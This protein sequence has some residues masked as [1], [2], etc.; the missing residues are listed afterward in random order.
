MNEYFMGIDWADRMCSD[1][2]DD[3]WEVFKQLVNDAAIQFVPTSTPKASKSPPWWTKSISVAIK[4]KHSALSR[5]RRS[6]S[7]ADYANYKTKRNIVKC[8]LRT[9]QK[10]YEQSLLNKFKSNPKAFYSYV[11]S[12]QKVKPSIGPLEKT[13]GSSTTSDEEIT[14]VLNRYFESTFTQEDLS[15]IPSPPFRSE[16]SIC[17]VNISES[18][19]LE[20]LS[21]LKDKT[22]GPDSIH[23]YVLKACAHALCTPYSICP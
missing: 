22:P 3:N 2:I 21:T 8:K 1:S 15:Y 19:V 6:R 5:Y 9:A 12:K 20:K 18:I 13:D 11:K 17:D 4:A 23:S 14:D 10:T 16:E 7:C